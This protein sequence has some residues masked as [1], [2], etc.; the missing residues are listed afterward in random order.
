MYEVAARFADFMNDGPGLIWMAVVSGV[1]AVPL[2]LMH[3]IGHAVAAR[4]L[5]RGSVLVHV[6][7]G[8]A[9]WE[10]SAC[11]V[12]FRVA[13]VHPFAVPAGFCEYDGAG[14]RARD[15]VAVA[16]AG[17]AVTLLGLALS[18]VALAH[19]DGLVRAVVWVAV[20]AQAF[21]LVICLLP[22]TMTD[23]RGRAW[24]SDGR[25]ALDA[26]RHMTLP[27]R[28]A[29]VHAQAPIRLAVASPAPFSVASPLCASCLH[30]R[31]EHI[32]LAT[33]RAGACLGQDDDFQTLSARRCAC[34]AYVA[35][36]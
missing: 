36:R 27:A 28:R 17:P 26:L 10:F 12:E 21:A 16:L 33:G 32:D 34:P 30:G 11:G 14:A 9:R 19:V 31:D 24:R 20:I 25:L 13:L 7:H 22:L 6:G 5:L 4:K 3:E 8:H 23:R 2:T 35:A 18:L 1:L 15:E 29:A